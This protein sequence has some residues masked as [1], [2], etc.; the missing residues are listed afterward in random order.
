MFIRKKRLVIPLALVLLCLFVFVNYSPEQTKFWP[1]RIL[2]KV[3]HGLQSSYHY[4]T[5]TFS[6]IFRHYVFL[7]G[8]SKEN[9]KLRQENLALSTKALRLKELDIELS[10]L[11]VLL[12]LKKSLPTQMVAATVTS[13]NPQ[14][15]SSTL[16]I[17]KGTAHGVKRFAGVIARLGFVGYVIEAFEHSSLVLFATN[18]YAVIEVLCQRSRTKILIQG[19]RKGMYAPYLGDDNNLQKGDLCVT[20]SPKKIQLPKGIPVGTI[21]K[22]EDHPIEANQKV[23]LKPTTSISQI[24]NVLVTIPKDNPSL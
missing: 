8:V 3:G 2:T 12:D 23:F 4:A 16:T 14:P 15:E 21:T 17:N 19:Y 10:Q 24:E 18:R 7:I 5:N 22:I 20:H 11:K 9:D 1:L 13:Y 6:S